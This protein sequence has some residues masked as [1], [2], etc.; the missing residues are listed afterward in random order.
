MLDEN[1]EDKMVRES[2]KEQVSES[3]GE[4][5][6]LL[7]NILRRKV[8]WIGHTSILRR[9]FLLHDA[10]EGQMTEIK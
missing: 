3:I 8:N 2:N 9:N 4:K 6:K 5:R 7:N 10:L 1:G